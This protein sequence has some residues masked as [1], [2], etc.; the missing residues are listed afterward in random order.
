[1][2]P[3]CLLGEAQ[4]EQEQ[5]LGVGFVGTSGIEL[6]RMLN[7]AGA[8]RLT[9]VDYDYINKF[10]R[11]SDPSFIDMIWRLHPEFHRTNV[12]Q[13]RPPGNKIEALCGSKAEAITG[14]PSIS[15]SK[16]V[17]REFKSELERLGDELVQLDPNL[18]IC[19]GNSALWAMCGTTGVSK[20]RGTTAI[21]THTASGFKCLATYHPAAVL[22]Q[23]ELRPVTII[24]LAKA[25]R[26]ALFP[27]IKRPKRKIWI[28][29]GI[30][31]MECFNDLF[32]T[33]CQL[34]SVDIET[35]GNQVTCIGFSPTPSTALVVPFLDTRRSDRS[36]WHNRE[37]E[38]RAW[39]IIRTILE[40]GRIKKTFQNG[41]YDIA[42]LL[43]SVGIKVM[44][45]EHDTM[46]CHHAL[47]PESLKGLGFLG[48]VYCDEGAWKGMRKKDDT[49]KRDA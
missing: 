20:L 47:Q 15:K 30:E 40:D 19:L 43:R 6:L 1:M 23:W 28:E 31:D 4:G 33:N 37:D 45:A 7:E 39:Q 41:L 25:S 21:S 26:E 22:R 2:K 29:P 34:L 13:L 18:I 27:D 3:I 36:Y 42:F 48:S 24:D 49:I 14:Y 44:G 5:K 16:Y 10:Y 46:L 11:Q 9:S 38:A 8:L 12:F 35:A 32:I 17:R